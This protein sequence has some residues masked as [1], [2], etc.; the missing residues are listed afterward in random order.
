MKDYYIVCGVRDTGSQVVK[1]QK[2]MK[3][4][5]ILVEIDPIKVTSLKNQ[6]PE[7]III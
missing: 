4:N 1:E 6:F 3:E 2:L 5:Y 7:I